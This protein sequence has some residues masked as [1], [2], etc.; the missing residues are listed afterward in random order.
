MEPKRFNPKLIAF[1]IS[2][3][4]AG[5][6]VAGWLAFGQRTDA[7]AEKIGRIVGLLIC[8]APGWYVLERVSAYAKRK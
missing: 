4:V 7:Q 8:I 3:A 5:L 6:I 2:I 1:L